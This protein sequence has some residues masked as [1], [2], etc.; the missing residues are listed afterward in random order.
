MN[1]NIEKFIDNLENIW[2]QAKTIN[3][4]T[5]FENMCRRYQTLLQEEMYINERKEEILNEKSFIK[6]KILNLFLEEEPE[7]KEFDATDA[8]TDATTDAADAADI[9]AKNN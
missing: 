2:V 3:K 8:T 9:E 4:D 5:I 1:N 6:N 7:N